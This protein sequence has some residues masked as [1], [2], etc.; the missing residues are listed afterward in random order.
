L[1]RDEFIK[2]Q[3]LD[4][5]LSKQTFDI[6][7]QRKALL[8]A[9]KECLPQF[10]GELL[11][12]GCGQMPYREMVVQQ[13]QT[14]SRYIGLDLQSS[15]VHDT[16]IADLHWDGK[17]IPL[18]DNRIDTALST[19]VLE[20]SFNPTHTLLEINRVLRPGGLF[21]F[22]VPFIWPFHE[23]PFD[24]YRYTPFSLRM[25]LEE[26]GF[27]DIKINSLGGWHASFAQM[28]GLWVKE[29]GLSRWEKKI[30]SRIAKRLIPYLLRKD[31]KDNSFGHHSMVSGLYGT[32]TKRNSL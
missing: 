16:S 32:A 21:F 23:V 10:R 3:F 11:D 19:E 25:H 22:T 8:R 4:V 24:A 20:H 14:V 18:G 29:G 7:V 2:Q 27:T 26:A 30:A 12:V 9:I 5:E 17:K 1:N 6:Y 15:S 31:I 28:F 13:N